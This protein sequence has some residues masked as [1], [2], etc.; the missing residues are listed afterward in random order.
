LNILQDTGHTGNK[1]MIS[2]SWH[3]L[4]N[5]SLYIFSSRWI[6]TIE[7]FFFIFYYFCNQSR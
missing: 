6:F 5:R 1:G 7:T 3:F 2:P 4:F